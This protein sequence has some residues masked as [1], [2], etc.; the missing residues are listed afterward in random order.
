MEVQAWMRQLQRSC[1]RGLSFDLLG[2]PPTWHAPATVAGLEVRFYEERTFFPR[3]GWWGRSAARRLTLRACW[4]S[5]R[6]AS[7]SVLFTS[8]GRVYRS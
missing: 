1:V 4:T 6:E 8:D 5:G 3:G 7:W 2:G